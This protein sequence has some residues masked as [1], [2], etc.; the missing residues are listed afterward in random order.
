MDGA[1][2]LVGLETASDALTDA[3][4]TIATLIT[5]NA[6]VAVF[7]IGIPVVFIGVKLFKK[8]IH[9]RA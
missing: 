8:L 6:T 5:T 1:T 4:S 2:A 3:F 7:A 9:T